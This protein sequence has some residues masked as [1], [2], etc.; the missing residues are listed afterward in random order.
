VILSPSGTYKLAISMFSTGGE[1]WNYSQGIV[2]RNDVGRG[3][4]ANETDDRPIATIQRNY[5]A[6]PY[7]FVEGHPKG[8]FLVCGQDYQGQT[9]IELGSG[10]RR[11]A[12]SEGSEQ[13]TGFCWAAYAFDA[14]SKILVVDGC[15]WACPYEYRFFDFSDPM[16]GWPPIETE[17]Y[18]DVDEKPP[19]IEGDLVRCFLTR[20]ADPDEGDAGERAPRTRPRPVDAILTFRREGLRLV[21]VEEWVSDHEKARRVEREEAAKKYEAWLASFKA[22]DPLYLAYERLVED[23]ARRVSVGRTY[24]GWC[25][26]FHLEE[27]RCCRRIVEREGANGATIDLEWAVDTGPIKLVLYRDSRA[28]G[29]KFFEHSVLGME[30]AFAFAEEYARESAPD[31]ERR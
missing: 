6:F 14:P 27:R 13:G 24:E 2:Y 23:P 3:A 5:G 20:D 7:L 25:P 4:A 30:Q 17:G 16:S 28:D 22:T 1:S 18:V 19:V 9:V 21:A 10:T 31:A 12:M 11:D 29:H 26:D 15:L 8:D